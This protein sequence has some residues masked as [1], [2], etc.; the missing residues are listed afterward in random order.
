M[1]AIWIIAKNTYKEIIRDRVLYGILIF[2]I[3][4]FGL[5][6][7]LGQLSFTE[8]S[9]ISANFGL[10]AIQIGAAI[11]SIFVGSTLVG[12][13]IEKKTI[14][15]LL[16]RPVNRTQFIIGKTL[17]LWAVVAVCVTGLALVLALILYLA[18]YSVDG[19]FLLAL[20][21]VMLESAVL[22][23]FTVFFGSFASPMLSVSFVIG[24]FLIG[25]WVESLKFFV[26]NSKSKTFKMV[27]EA[28]TTV[29]PNLEM[30]NWRSLFI[31]Q[32]AIPW[33]DFGTAN[34]YM[35]SWVVFLIMFSA[36][37]L[38]RRDLG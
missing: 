17:G 2:A 13:E 12:R 9:R 23:A 31:Y 33:G 27:G 14:L 21:G 38:G 19:L 3:L 1:K 6:M 24:I 32:D 8:Q 35:L 11:L 20:H 16:T 30:F 4:L 26:D 28:I 22:L 5:S 36:I 18:D 15:T 25:H 34:I 10:A 29:M 7:A 37:I